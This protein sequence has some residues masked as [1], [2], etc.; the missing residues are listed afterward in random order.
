[1]QTTTAANADP[2]LELTTK[3]VNSLE[4]HM[5]LFSSHAEWCHKEF[6]KKIPLI[7]AMLS[8]LPDDSNF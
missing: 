7:T 1:M 5:N 8:K 2:T 4:N 6:N 3:Q